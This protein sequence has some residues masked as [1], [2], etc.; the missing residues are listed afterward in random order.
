MLYVNIKLDD[1]KQFIFDASLRRIL[2]D[3]ANADNFEDEDFYPSYL[4]DKRPK[5]YYKFQKEN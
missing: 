3:L 1:K 4:N 5:R 2:F